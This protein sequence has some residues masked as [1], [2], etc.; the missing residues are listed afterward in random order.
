MIFCRCQ[1]RHEDQHHR[2]KVNAATG[3]SNTGETRGD[4]LSVLNPGRQ[5]TQQTNVFGFFLQIGK[6][7]AMKS[8]NAS[9]LRESVKGIMLYSGSKHI[10]FIETGTLL[11]SGGEAG[12]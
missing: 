8:N 6:C 5:L 10:D 9:S 2:T 4:L 12:F 11:H 3:T 1:G 7:H